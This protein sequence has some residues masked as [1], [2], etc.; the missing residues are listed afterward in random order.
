[1]NVDWLVEIANGCIKHVVTRPVRV[2]MYSVLHVMRQLLSETWLAQLTPSHTSISSCRT[3]VCK[4]HAKCRYSHQVDKHALE[5]PEH[6]VAQ[7]RIQNIYTV[8]LGVEFV[9]NQC[10][11]ITSQHTRMWRTTKIHCE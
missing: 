8:C 9:D 2:Y 6:S 3:P 11:R 5:Q 1:M 10:S 7:K 4:Y